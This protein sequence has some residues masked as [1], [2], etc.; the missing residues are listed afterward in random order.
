MTTLAQW[1]RRLADWL[2]PSPLPTLA[3]AAVPLIHAAATLHGTSGEYRR[4][5]VYAQLRKDYPQ[6]RGR[7]LALAIET[8]IAH[9]ALDT[10]G[11]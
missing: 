4:H 10:E 9:G 2:D 6:A 8:A 11:R 7:D 1:L 3:A 5:V